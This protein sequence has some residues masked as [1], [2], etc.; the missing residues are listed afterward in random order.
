[1]F[2]RS[3]VF[4]FSHSSIFSIQNW[5]CQSAL[6]G[7]KIVKNHEKWWLVRK[8]K[9]LNLR[10]T[11]FYM[12]VLFCVF[13]HCRVTQWG[14]PELPCTFCSVADVCRLFDFGV[15]RNHGAALRRSD[16]KCWNPAH[17]PWKAPVWNAT[18]Q[19]VSVLRKLMKAGG[20]PRSYT[21]EEDREKS[22]TAIL[23]VSV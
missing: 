12:F 11:F 2:W 3:G 8:S 9:K 22:R 6:P 19:S 10:K 1:M 23:R 14:E 21:T 20:G 18:S 5:L 17:P 13:R 16:L 15:G 7:S 4:F